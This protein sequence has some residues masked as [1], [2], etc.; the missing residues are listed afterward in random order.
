M[1]ITPTWINTM[2]EINYWYLLH[3]LAQWRPASLQA[4]LGHGNFNQHQ[5]NQSNA[6]FSNAFLGSI[7]GMNVCFLGENRNFLKK[8]FK[9]TKYT[10][11]PSQNKSVNLVIKG[12]YRFTDG[13]RSKD[14]FAYFIS[15][16][17]TCFLAGKIASNTQVFRA[18][19]KPPSRK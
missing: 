11:A 7:C 4:S 5:S 6:V 12:S 18:Q 14:Q 17:P 16:P 15:F 19:T 2:W 13:I 1:E 10:E 9:T 8:G 3:K